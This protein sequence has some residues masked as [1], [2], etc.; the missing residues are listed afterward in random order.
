MDRTNLNTAAIG[1]GAM[2]LRK[3]KPRVRNNRCR[4]AVNHAN[5]SNDDANV[6]GSRQSADGLKGT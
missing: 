3:E 2:L 4:P 5:G 6:K 1:N